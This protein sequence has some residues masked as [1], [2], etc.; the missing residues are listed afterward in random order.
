[1]CLADVCFFEQLAEYIG[2]LCLRFLF[3]DL[4]F[5]SFKVRMFLFV[6]VLI[7]VIALCF[8]V[9]EFLFNFRQPCR[10]FFA[11]SKLIFQPVNNVCVRL[12]DGFDLFI[13]QPHAFE[14]LP[15]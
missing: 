3:C 13:G 10:T 1:M 11:F 4:G 5:I 7:T 9:V 12:Y 8:K 6:L 2:F 15:C 14:Q